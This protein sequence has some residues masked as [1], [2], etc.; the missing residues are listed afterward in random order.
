LIHADSG[1]DKTK[2]KQEIR[3]SSG[4]TDFATK[5]SKLWT[6]PGP[7]RE[8]FLFT[9]KMTSRS[10]DFKMRVYPQIGYMLVLLFLFGFRSLKHILAI[11][12]ADFSSVDERAIFFILSIIYIS[13]FVF[14]GAVLQLAFTENFKSAWVY[15]IAPVTQPGQII[16][17]SIKAC[18]SKFLFPIAVVV[19]LSGL[20]L[21]GTAVIP[22][23]LFGFGNVWLMCNMLSWLAMDRLPFSIS[24]KNQKKGEISTRNFF[25]LIALPFFG[26][27][28]YFLFH[29]PVI[30]SCLSIITI[31]AGT[32]ILIYTGN[33][34]WKYIK[35]V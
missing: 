2:K 5:I 9:W 26:I 35:E 23:F 27:P 20:I 16:R 31:T 6:K 17:G 14:M 1:D 12:N 19:I 25:M 4:K 30:L 29:H 13:G 18:L 21:F 22:N 10:R 24:I 11:D 32:I 34:S 8:A 33:I 3:R 7:E 15:Y 28:H